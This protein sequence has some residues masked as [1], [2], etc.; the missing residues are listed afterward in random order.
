[1]HECEERAVFEDSPE[2]E[3]RS[4]TC[5]GLSML[6]R[7]LLTSLKIGRV[8]SPTEG[9]FTYGIRESGSSYRVQ[10]LRRNVDSL[11]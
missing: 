5:S 9:R 1:M 4:A 11:H 8:G 10:M 6:V 3:K 2:Q 7:I